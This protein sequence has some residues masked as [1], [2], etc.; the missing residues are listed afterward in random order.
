M[1]VLLVHNCYQS[2]HIGGEDLVVSRE[3]KAL[4]AHLG[5]KAV[6][7]YQVSNDDI[8][9]SK[10]MLSLWGDKTHYENIY[11]LV[12]THSI[13]IVHVHNFFPLLTPVVFSAAKKAGA[14][15]VHTLHN[16]RWWCLSGNF[17]REKKGTCEACVNKNLAWPAIQHRCYRQSS[18]QSAVGA[19][20]FSWYHL[21]D[22][23]R[24]IDAY[25]VLTDFQR[26][27]VKSWLPEEK[28][29][30]KPNPIEWPSVLGESEV[31]RDFLYI[32]RLEPAK[33]I[34]D[35]LSTW[36]QLPEDMILNVIGSGDDDLL[37]RY[38]HRKNIHFLGKVSHEKTIDYIRKSK[39]FIHPSLTY[40]TFGLTLVEALAHGT[41]V[42]AFDIG[43]RKEFVQP[44]VNGWLCDKHTL[45]ETILEANCYQDYAKLSKSAHESV[46][47]FA[48]ETVINKQIKWYEK[49]CLE[50]RACDYIDHY[51]LL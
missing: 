11:R 45:K 15:V 7:N 21:K 3:T 39:Y 16:F 32:G 46:K 18:L 28:L 51:G 38:S 9:A 42:I 27:K 10:L 6:F 50:E 37:Q 43:P 19:A 31:K 30:L 24:Y 12:K 13:D 25:F 34:V 4:K 44:K 26:E 47:R 1:K 48:L 36:E 8:H 14:K 23:H 20:A 17:Y 29:W 41:P 33:G 5:E 40:E 49:I 2:R 22:Y 35:L